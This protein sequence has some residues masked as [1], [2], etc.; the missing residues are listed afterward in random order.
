[1]LKG[2]SSLSVFLLFATFCFTQ[3]CVAGSPLS[4]FSQNS[5]FSVWADS[6]ELADSIVSR[7]EALRKKIAK[8]WLGEE[9]PGG[10]G[11]TT[12]N[13]Y[14]SDED[15]A[16]T[17]LLDEGSKRTNHMTWIYTSYEKL[18]STLAHEIAHT[19]L[20]CR[21]P[22]LP[23][24]A[25]E[26][27]ASR[28]DEEERKKIRRNVLK[29]FAKTNRWPNVEKILSA[30]AISPSNHTAYTASV[31]VTEFLLSR[32]SDKSKFLEFASSAAKHKKWDS[33]L[34][35]HYGIPSV[36]DLQNQWQTWV[37]RKERKR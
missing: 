18:D 14:F 15:S 23:A 36:A 34:Q 25:Q 10:F 3:V 9:V 27:A 28:Y 26:G 19:V 8:E 21:F 31:S 5:N 30:E 4:G 33:A 24:F 22:N 17:W 32:D 6:Q 2:F 12:I 29:W 7:S 1:M 13:V 16:R 20:W 11:P 35:K 37:T